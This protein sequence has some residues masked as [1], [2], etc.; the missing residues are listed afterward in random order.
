M[1]E[2]NDDAVTTGERATEDNEGHRSGEEGSPERN[3]DQQAKLDTAAE[4][5]IEVEEELGHLTK[6]MQVRGRAIDVEQ[7]H[8]SAVPADY[9]V[10]VT[11]TD[12]LALYVV[13]EGTDEQTVVTYFE[14]PE[15]KV[16]DRLATLLDLQDVPMDRFAD[17]HGKTVLL[18]VQDEYYVPALPEEQPRGK[19]TAVYGIYAGLGVNLALALTMI[20]GVE[21]LAASVAFVVVWL[22]ANLVVLPVSTYL[23]AWDRRTTTTW[24]GG[25]LFWAVLSLVPGINVM[26]VAAYL[27]SRQQAEPLA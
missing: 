9:P 11:T 1:G 7:V 23:D 19:R 17:L 10:A 18:E 20:F 26:T 25:P 2:K 8:A 15:T 22:L 5:F 13:L 21:W 4:S 6:A 3:G 14:W 27:V 24:E 16:S 12:A